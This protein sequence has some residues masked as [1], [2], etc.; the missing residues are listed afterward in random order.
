MRTRVTNL[1]KEFT[2][3]EQASG[4]L[5]ILATILSI[6]LANSSIG[7]AYQHFWHHKIGPELNILGLHLGLHLSIEHWINDGLMAIFFLLI[8][9]EIEREIY[10]GELSNLRQA[11]LPI[12]AAI[13]GMLIPALIH[14]GFNQGTATQSGFGIPM[15]TDIAFALG[16][17]TLLGK[18]VPISLKIFLTALAIID[19]LGAILV[20]A[21]FYIGNFSFAYFSGAVALFL[22]MWVMNRRGVT[23]VSL[24][25]LLGV[26][27]W[28]CMLKSGIHATLAG[29]LLAFVLPYGN[30]DEHSPSFHLQHLLHK[31][32]AFLIMPIFALANTGISLAGDLGAALTSLNSLGIIV[33]LLLGKP[34]GIALASWLTIQIGWS[35]LPE[36]V[37]WKHIWGAGILGG[38]GFTMSIF[39]SNLAYTDPHI[40]QISK[41]AVLTA[42]TCAG[43]IGYSVLKKA[44]Q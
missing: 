6:A 11:I 5:L 19:D 13:G 21:L 32:V 20:I 7:P 36:G 31:P 18:R 25:L 12:A 15:A 43:L 27:M 26:L 40:I 39:I 24:Y 33:G 22:L 1:Y 42:S 10:T 37:Q 17:L 29:V 3:S 16:V 9:L 41:I 34:I 8:G 28:Y 14:F 23:R 30:G 2:A 44:S 4:I 38:I 35:Q